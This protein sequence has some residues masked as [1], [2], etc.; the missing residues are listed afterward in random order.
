MSKKNLRRNEKEGY[1]YKDGRLHGGYRVYDDGRVVL[2]NGLASSYDNL[3]TD[4]SALHEFKRWAFDFMLSQ[5]KE[6]QRRVKRFWDDVAKEV[7]LVCP[8]PNPDDFEIH[9]DQSTRTITR[10]PKTKPE[11]EEPSSATSADAR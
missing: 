11:P 5:Q 1:E 7:Q 6:L 8:V 4:N 3:N 2:D 10:K 9:Y